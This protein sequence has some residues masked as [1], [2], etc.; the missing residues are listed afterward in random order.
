[1]P[2]RC[3]VA[4]L[5]SRCLAIREVPGHA[6]R[7]LL[8]CTSIVCLLLYH[9]LFQF[10]FASPDGTYL[11][12]NS[13]SPELIFL[14]CRWYF[15][16]S[17]GWHWAVFFF[18]LVGTYCPMV[19]SNDEFISISATDK[20]CNGLPIIFSWRICYFHLLLKLVDS[21]VTLPFA[22]KSQPLHMARL[23]LRF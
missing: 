10:S 7:P 20:T 9:F 5:V 1:M 21:L 17:L 8:L 11:F 18:G 22:S 6:V 16:F 4:S 14:G 3:L 13:S 15:K 23:C 19:S 2:P 12:F